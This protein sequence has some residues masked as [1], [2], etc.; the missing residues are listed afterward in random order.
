MSKNLHRGSLVGLALASVAIAACA[1]LSPGDQAV[2]ITRAESVV[3][4]CEKVG[5][6]SAEDARN[7][8]QVTA[9]LGA[10]ARSKK[11]NTVLLTD[12]EGL[13][14]VAYRCAAPSAASAPATGR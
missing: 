5:D 2:T 8:D 13:R 10:A 11:A 6:V 1:S 12:T 9:E 7:A 3:A 4:S 14:G